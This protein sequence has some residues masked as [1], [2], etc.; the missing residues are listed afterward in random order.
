MQI[1]SGGLSGLAEAPAVRL[2]LELQAASGAILQRV[3]YPVPALIQAGGCV[4]DL[5]QQV[6]QE[7]SERLHG[8]GRRCMEGS[9]MITAFPLPFH[10][11][12]TAFP[13]ARSSALIFFR[14]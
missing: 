10:C 12:S 11:L 4:A 14:A 8:M 6:R 7:G 9:A 2:R 5:A 3:V 13:S 1:M